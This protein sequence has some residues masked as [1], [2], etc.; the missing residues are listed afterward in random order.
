MGA[1]QSTVETLQEEDEPTWGHRGRLCRG[2]GICTAT[3][4][5]DFPGRESQKGIRGIDVCLGWGLHFRQQHCLCK[6]VLSGVFRELQI[7]RC[8]WNVTV[9]SEE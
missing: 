8:W 6:H 9:V 3:V 7:G 2:S 4:R 1:E 5:R